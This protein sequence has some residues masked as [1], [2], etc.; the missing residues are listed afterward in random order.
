MFN[1]I[2]AEAQQRFINLIDILVDIDVRVTFHSSH[3]LHRFLAAASGR[4]DAFRMQSRMQLL[5]RDSTRC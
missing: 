2:D 3:T 4:P 5:R 1:G